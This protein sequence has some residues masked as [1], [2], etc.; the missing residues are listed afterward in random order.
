MDISTLV[1]T[2]LQIAQ[3]S[4]SQAASKPGGASANLATAAND[5]LGRELQ[6][7]NVKL[8]AYGQIKS[9]FGGAQTAATGLTAAATSKTA[10]NADIEKA[11]QAFVSAYNQATQSVS[12]ATGTSA[13]Q[14]GALATDSRAR[15]AGT[16]LARSITGNTS[17]ASLKQIGITMNKNG[18]MSLDTKALQAAL[19]SNPSQAKGALANLGQQV[20]AATSR[21]LASTGNVGISVGK[22]TTQ[23]Q[24]LTSRQ[25]T[26]QQTTASTQSQLE[27]QKTTLN[28]A[29]ANSLAAYQKVLG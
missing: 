14:V 8:S 2:G 22:L 17:P 12:S 23:A 11:A 18:T 21:E 3:L 13:K 5:R 28:Y 19:Q 6:S 4:Q 27:Q 15:A 9:A 10:T 24:T 16:D 29:T 7:T 25:Q 1:K 26:L 20:N